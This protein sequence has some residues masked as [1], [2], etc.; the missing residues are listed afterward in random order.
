[1]SPEST[2]SASSTDPASRIPATP[3]S[4]LDSALR[5]LT[6]TKETWTTWT[7]KERARLLDQLLTSFANVAPRWVEACLEAEGI[8]PANPTAAE[9]WLAGPYLVLRNLQLLKTS[10]LDL[11]AG[12][13][14]RIAGPISRRANG[15]VV[16]QVFPASLYDRLFYPGLT[17]ETWMEPT[18][19]AETLAETQS[20]AYFESPRRGGVA[21][22]LGAGNVSSIGPMDALYKLFVEDRVVLFKAHPVNDY[23]GPLLEE[24]FAPLVERDLLQVVYGGAAEGAYLAQHEQVDE[25]HITGSDKT[26]EAIVFGAGEAGQRAKAERR[27]QNSKV[28][29]SELGNVSPVLIVPGPWKDSDFEYHAENLA[30]MLVNNAGFNCNATR[31]IVTAAGWS[32]RDKLLSALRARL[33]TV[34][35]RRAFYP[36]AESR[37]QAF[38]QSHPQGEEFGPGGFDRL[39]WL[40]IPAVPPDSIDELCFT[41]EAFAPVFAEVALDAIEAPEFLEQAVAFA[42]ERLWGTLNACLLV[43]PGTRRRHPKAVE[44][45]VADLRYGTVAINHWP[46]V[47]YGLVVTPWGAFPGSDLYDIQSGSG[48]VHNTL[49]FDR[50]QK[51]V[52]RAPF[53]AFPKPPWFPSHRTA[54]KLARVLTEFEATR[55][56]LKLPRIFAL[57]AAG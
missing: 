19:T 51:A 15:Q 44:T 26:V 52:I 3:K 16:A 57:A 7:A 11:A 34:P 55:S 30:A 31:V 49:M 9:E 32:G 18:V 2:A 28:I 23:L 53:R 36:G 12:R 6:E 4:G 46:A 39:P 50:A 14:P 8:P 40:F 29:T 5:T 42:N 20:V 13:R 22:V 45:A 54:H 56:P 27:P 35:T 24:G 21:L 38:R 48:W 43:H 25:I 10:L 47:G 33:A 17:A 41:T 1:M 37:W